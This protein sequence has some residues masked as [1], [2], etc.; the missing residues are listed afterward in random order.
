MEGKRRGLQSGAGDW[1][2]LLQLDSGEN[3]AGTDWNGGGRIYF[4]ILKDDLERRDFRNV[5]SALQW[6]YLS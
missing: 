1:L 4:L 2:L 3:C 5:H 6:I